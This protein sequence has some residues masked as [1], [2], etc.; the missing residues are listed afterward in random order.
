MGLMISFITDFKCHSP[1]QFALDDQVPFV[2]QRIAEIRLNATELMVRI[3]G[4]GIRRETSR[5]PPGMYW[6]LVQF[7]SE[8]PRNEETDTRQSGSTGRFR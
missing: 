5:R 3:Q 7:G 2:N 1:R 8:T 6:Q 4:E